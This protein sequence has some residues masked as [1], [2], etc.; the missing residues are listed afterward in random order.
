MVVT[1]AGEGDTVISG[2]V[3]MVTCVGRAVVVVCVGD[4]DVVLTSLS[5]VLI[6]NTVAKT[7]LLWLDSLFVTVA[8][9]DSIGSLS[10]V[11]GVWINVVSL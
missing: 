8:S 4:N 11:V 2:V 3:V 6:D 9:I 5:S 7:L 1:V 10:L